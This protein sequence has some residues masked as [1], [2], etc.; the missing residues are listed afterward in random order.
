MN[1]VDCE[2]EAS[3]EVMNRISIEEG[4]L[5]NE[6]ELEN[7]ETR[8]A[9]TSRLNERMEPSQLDLEKRK[10]KGGE[11]RKKMRNVSHVVYLFCVR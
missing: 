4:D 11:G 1:V 8:T 5:M 9:R 10:A 3:L 6:C 7:G 2:L